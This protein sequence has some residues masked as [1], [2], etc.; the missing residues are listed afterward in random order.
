MNK[1]QQLDAEQ[2]YF[3]SVNPHTEVAPEQIVAEFTYSHPQYDRATQSAQIILRSISGSNKVHF[4][5]AYL[6]HG[7]HEDGFQSGLRVACDLAKSQTLY[8]P[9]TVPA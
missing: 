9:V 7:F 4:A 3:I 1:L 5:G 8:S 6:G 2:D